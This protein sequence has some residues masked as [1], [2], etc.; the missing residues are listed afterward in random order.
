MFETIDFKSGQVEF[1]SESMDN[2]DIL[3]VI[4]PNNYILDL[5]W[6]KKNCFILYII[7]NMNWSMPVA[8]Y[9]FS[10]EKLAE[11]ILHLAIEKIEKELITSNLCYNPNYKTEKIII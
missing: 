11:N 7:H 9:H 10:N 4:F 6:Y 3:Q 1:C 2:E 8:E 5:G